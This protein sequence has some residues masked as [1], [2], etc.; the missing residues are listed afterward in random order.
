MILVDTHVALWLSGEPHRISVAGRRAIADTLS[1]GETLAICD[2]SFLEFAMLLRK[3]R[4][5]MTISFESFLEGLQ[6]HFTVLPITPK[7]CSRIAALPVYF[8][9]DPADQVIAATALAEGIPLMTAD[10]AI[11]QSRAVRTIW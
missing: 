10:R 9:N 7:A 2:I 6:S 3:R 8:P 1:G 11:R 5:Q 4:L